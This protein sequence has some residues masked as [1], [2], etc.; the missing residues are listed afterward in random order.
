MKACIVSMKYNIKNKDETPKIKPI[1]ESYGDAEKVYQ[2]L[3]ETLGWDRDDVIIFTDKK[4]NM[5]NLYNKI[6]KKIEDLKTTTSLITKENAQH[7]NVLAFIGHGA[8]NE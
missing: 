2:L 6:N 3:T 4:S 8:I 1:D 5:K 7:L